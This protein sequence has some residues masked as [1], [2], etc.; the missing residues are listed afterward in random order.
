MLLCLRSSCFGSSLLL[1]GSDVWW[2]LLVQTVTLINAPPGDA[3]FVPKLVCYVQTASGNIPA[4][5]R[6][7]DNTNVNADVQ[8]LQQQLQDIK[9]QVKPRHRI[10]YTPES[11]DRAYR[12]I[13][14]SDV[15]T[16]HGCEGSDTKKMGNL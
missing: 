14:H 3:V 16:E 2:G 9:E 13:G 11:D 15:I 5:Q 7:K 1:R 6:D 10:Q 4:L 8:K 12:G